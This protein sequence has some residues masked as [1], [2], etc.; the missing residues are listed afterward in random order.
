[1]K[2]IVIKKDT[3]TSIAIG[4]FDGMHLGHQK[5]FDKLDNNGGIVVIQTHY[6]NLSPFMHRKKHT[7]YPLYFYPL[8]NIKHLDGK[9]FIK[10]LKEEFPNL[11]KIVVG[12]DFHFGYLASCNDEDLKR[13]F[14]GEVEVVA[15]FCIDTK[16]VHSKVIR[17]FL[18][19]GDIQTANKFLGYNYT[20]TGLCVQG[21]GLGKKA[22]VPTINVIIKNF[23][24]P[25]EGVYLTKTHLNNKHYASLTFIGNRFTTDNKFAVETHIIENDFNEEIPKRI[26]IEFLE[27]LRDN[28]AF[29][30]FEDLKNQINRDLKKALL[31]FKEKNE[32]CN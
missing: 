29:E 17:S 6:A 19:D 18:R 15:E 12:Y 27:K 11:Q 26:E 2:G 7:Q 21:Q 1:M 22:F 9:Q 30:C 28:Q 23:L 14:L 16:A 31:W 13:L 4:G 32:K 24:I 5:L 10:L 20:F 25:Q 3:I 8:E